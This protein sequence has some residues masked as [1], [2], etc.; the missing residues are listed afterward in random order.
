MGTPVYELW[1]SNPES[2]VTAV[3][4]DL[5]RIE[6]PPGFTDAVSVAGLAVH[7]ERASDIHRLV[8]KGRVFSRGELHQLLSEA[9]V[10]YGWFFV[11]APGRVGDTVPPVDVP[12]MLRHSAFVVDVLE[13]WHLGV[14]SV[15][16]TLRDAARE[17]IA[18][19]AE[20]YQRELTEVRLAC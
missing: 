7:S 3:V 14:H 17:V 2:G 9:E 19:A 1:T 15:H 10:Q 12:A 6:L 18:A 5:L 11:G 4:S 8:R 20:L 16:E 13:G